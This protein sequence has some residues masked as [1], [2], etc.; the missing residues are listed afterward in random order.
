MKRLL[1]L[2][3]VV[4][5]SF[6]AGTSPAQAATT[7]TVSNLALTSWSVQTDVVNT[8]WSFTCG[9]STGG[10]SEDYILDE[11]LQWRDGSGF[12][13]TFDCDNGSLCSAQKPSYPN[14]FAHGSHHSGTNTWNVAGNIDCHYVRFH[15]TVVFGNQ[16]TE[17]HNSIVYHIGSC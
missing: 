13:H 12:W 4:V 5:A 9:S 15:T 6:G 17:N 3:A 16:D 2:L 8:S 11:R 1:V 14:S 7:C 10:S